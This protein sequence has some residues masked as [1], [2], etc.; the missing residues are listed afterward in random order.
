MK[1]AD[2]SRVFLRNTLLALSCLPVLAAAAAPT[3]LI[4][5]TRGASTM[6][7]AGNPQVTMM[8]T[9]LLMLGMT[10]NDFKVVHRGPGKSGGYAQDMLI[11][12][13]IHGHPETLGCHWKYEINAYGGAPLYSVAPFPGQGTHIPLYQMQ[14]AHDLVPGDYAFTVVAVEVPGNTCTG[15]TQPGKFSVP[16]PSGYVR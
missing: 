1:N 7:Q 3:G 11:N 15:R 10:P 6:Q 12:F 13:A 2:N 9:K 5:K 16:Y 4:E 8:K 14:V